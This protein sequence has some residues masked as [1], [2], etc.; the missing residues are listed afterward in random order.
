MYSSYA[1]RV[2]SVYPCSPALS[3]GLL[4]YLDF[5]LYNPSSNSSVLLSEFLLLHLSSPVSVHVYNL[6]TQTIRTV[7][8]TPSSSFKATHYLGCE[9]Q[10]EEFT[11]VADRVFMVD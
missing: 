1:Y 9:L 10:F 6:A 8:I 2:L 3:S 5:I 4:P 7:T 11:H